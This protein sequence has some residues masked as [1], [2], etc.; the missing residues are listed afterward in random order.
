MYIENQ[1]AEAFQHLHNAYQNFERD[2]SG[3][4]I[5]KI[6]R[7]EVNTVEFRPQEG[8]SFIPLPAKIQKKRAVVNIQN[9]DQKCF[10]WSVLAALHPVARMDMPSRLSHYL[11]YQNDL[12]LT[13]LEFPLP[14]SQ[15]TKFNTNNDISINVF[16]L[17][18]SE[19]YPLQLTNQR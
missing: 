11:S 13:G 8:S 14:L 16:G 5:D 3:W 7:L 9:E 17:E 19:V 4:S 18:G 6:L 15:I 10:Q 12:N 1:L 2:G